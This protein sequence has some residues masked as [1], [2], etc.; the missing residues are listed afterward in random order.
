MPALGNRLG[1]VRDS[2]LWVVRGSRHQK[3]DFQEPIDYRRS[4]FQP[5]MILKNSQPMKLP[6]KIPTGR[7]WWLS[8]GIH[9]SQN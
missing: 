5:E 3:L 7:T 9:R 2:Q 1:T 8:I 6:M 4:L